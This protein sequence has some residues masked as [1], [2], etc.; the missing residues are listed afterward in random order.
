[1]LSSETSISGGSSSPLIVSRTVRGF[2]ASSSEIIKFKFTIIIYLSTLKYRASGCAKTIAETEASG[3]I[4]NP[5][6]NS[7]PIS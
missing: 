4:I 7:T 6:V 3:S 1:M 5:S 2:T